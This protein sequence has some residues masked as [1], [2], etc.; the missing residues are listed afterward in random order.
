MAHVE[1]P[2]DKTRE[3]QPAIGVTPAVKLTVPEAED[4]VT[5][6]V[7]LTDPP[8]TTVDGE[9]VTEIEVGVGAIVSATV[10]ELP[11]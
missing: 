6:V 7:R 9:A 5:A 1:D 10:P 3:V 2:A 4:G 11:R 8:T